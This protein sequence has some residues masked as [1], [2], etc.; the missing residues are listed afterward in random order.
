MVALDH[1][2]LYS[3]KGPAGGPSTRMAISPQENLMRLNNDPYGGIHTNSNSKTPTISSKM[4]QR[5]ETN[6]AYSTG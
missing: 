4:N 2:K 3:L 1:D 6:Q 5:K